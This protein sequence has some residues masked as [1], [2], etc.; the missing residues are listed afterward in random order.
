MI[1]PYLPVRRGL[2]VR[3][4]PIIQ[5][6]LSGPRSYR[7]VFA[8]VDSGA[9][10]SLLSLELIDSLG[11]PTEGAEAVDVIGV[12]GN[13]SLGYLLDVDHQL[14]NHRWKAPAIF[15]SVIDAKSPMVLGQAGFFEYFN[16]NFKR[17]KSLIDICRAR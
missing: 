1:F 10:H 12:G 7:E 6:G 13:S 5:I 4:K 9:D 14:L 3:L 8:L 2:S 15:S 11:L 17:R 16:V